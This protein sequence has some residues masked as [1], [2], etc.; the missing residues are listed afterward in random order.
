M[1]EHTWIPH[2]LGQRRRHGIL[3][4][5]TFELSG[6]RR[7]VAR[8]RAEKMYAVPQPGPWW[9]AVGAPLERVVRPHCTVPVADACEVADATPAALT[10][11]PETRPDLS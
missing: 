11:K 4:C 10:V 2:K 3:C 5:L 9:P 8:A 7:Q 6:R 1:C